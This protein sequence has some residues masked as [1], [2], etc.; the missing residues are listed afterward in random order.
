[1]RARRRRLQHRH[2]DR[3][4]AHALPAATLADRQQRAVRDRLDEAVAQRVGR[5]AERADV[6][7]DGDELHDVGMGGA[8]LDQRPAQRLEEL[9]VEHV[10][11]AVLGDLARAA[12]HDVLVAL[13]AALGVVG[14]A[15]AVVD[16]LDLLEDEPVVVERAQRD[17][18]VLVSVSNGGPCDEA[19]GLVVEPGRRLAAVAPVL[20]QGGDVLGGKLPFGCSLRLRRLIIRRRAARALPTLRA[21]DL[22]NARSPGQRPRRKWLRK[23]TR[24]QT[25]LLS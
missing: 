16:G 2:D 12:G 4:A 3:G 19:V 24:S 18:I 17:H 5:D 6:V 7:L 1:M 23:R 11:G 10:P 25:S 13:A 8:R 21:R 9:A 14:R 22:W 20:R 15:Q